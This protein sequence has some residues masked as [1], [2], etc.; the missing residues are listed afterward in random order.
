MISFL[1]KSALRRATRA[2]TLI[3]LLVAT[4]VLALLLTLLAQII[5]G[6]RQTIA[7]NSSRIEA[8][9]AARGA[10]G[11]MRNDIRMMIRRPDVPIILRRLPGNDEFFFFA[12]APGRTA[13]P[14]TAADVS[15]VAIVGYRIDP[16]KGLQ[17]FS[18]AL[19]WDALPFGIAPQEMNDLINETDWD[20]I[21]PQILRL[22]LSLLG[23]DNAPL[24]AGSQQGP[25]IPDWTTVQGVSIDFVA[26]DSVAISH[27][28]P[29][30]LITEFPDGGTTPVSEAWVPLAENFAA[31]R[32]TY[33]KNLRVYEEH[34]I[35]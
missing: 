1:S 10:L 31:T 12:M 2:F 21:G 17:R 19:P 29:S 23:P 18:R 30:S 24:A 14:A 20:N 32:G 7:L 3:E 26:S 15:L 35:F 22:D 4:A 25:Y 27:L 9:L 5:S 6:T 13:Q 16:T 33:F 11:I 28:S 8:D 34:I